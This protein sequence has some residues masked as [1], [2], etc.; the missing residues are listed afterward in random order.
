M[1]VV[2]IKY[3]VTRVCKRSKDFVVYNLI[4]YN[5]EQFHRCPDNDGLSVVH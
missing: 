4:D 2:S 5:D 1:E 3:I